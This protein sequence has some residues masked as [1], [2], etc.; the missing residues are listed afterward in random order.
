MEDDRL[1]GHGHVLAGQGRADALLLAA[2][3]SKLKKGTHTFVV[4]A[5][6]P[7]GRASVKHTWR[8]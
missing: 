3:P 4:R 1:A 8:R 2:N 5:A 7:A 6:N